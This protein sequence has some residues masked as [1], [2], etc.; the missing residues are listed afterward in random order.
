M[1]TSLMGGCTSGSSSEATLFGRWNQVPVSDETTITL[2]DDGTWSGFS[3]FVKG[4]GW[5]G[6]SYGER[7]GTYALA[8]DIIR[9][10]V[11]AGYSSLERSEFRYTLDGDTLRLDNETYYREGS[12]AEAKARDAYVPGPGDWPQ[13]ATTDTQTTPY[14]VP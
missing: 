10:D 6:Y 1:M 7:I 13:E 14:T 11:E 3:G 4:N 12:L 8:G 2:Y 9:L 5:F